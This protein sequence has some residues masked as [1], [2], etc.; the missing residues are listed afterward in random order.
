MNFLK[1]AY[2]NK[3]RLDLKKI[4][5]R[6]SKWSTIKEHLNELL[7]R[8]ITFN[9]ETGK[10]YNFIVKDKKLFISNG[11]RTFPCGYI[12]K[13]SQ[14]NYFTCVIIIPDDNLKIY[15]INDV[16]N[17]GTIILSDELTP[18]Y[19]NETNLNV[20]KHFL[21][22]FN[23]TFISTNSLP[24]WHLRSII[25]L[26]TKLNLRE[27]YLLM[28]E[29]N[30]LS[31]LELCICSLYFKE[32]IKI[33]SFLI[34]IVFDNKISRGITYYHNAKEKAVLSRS[35][36]K[37]INEESF[38]EF[39]SKFSSD[40]IEEFLNLH[41]IEKIIN[42]SAINDEHVKLILHLY[43]NNLDDFYL[44]TP[45]YINAFNSKMN[46][47]NLTKKLISTFYQDLK[48]NLKKLEDMIRLEYGYEGVGSLY[49]ERFI[50]NS[51]KNHFKN[52]NIISEYSPDWLGRQRIDIFIEEINIGI[53]Y[54][55]KQHY[56]PI[57]FFG[58]ES[59]FLEIKRRDN[60]KKQ[61]CENNNV[62]LIEIKYNDD[63]NDSIDFIKKQ[64]DERLN[65]T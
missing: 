42:L 7:K 57:D 40:D 9:D 23:T 45:D 52:L 18:I 19:R 31:P 61:L 10:K 51:L 28:L 41:V 62:K 63:I 32:K 53:E 1:K 20:I 39:L 6:K 46:E 11:I 50:Y 8:E 12:V 38:L 36:I 64:I 43:P 49:S 24:K 37:I 14:G 5:L 30:I 54:N 60:L 17:W 16:K 13:G 58:G 29:H 4:H 65:L 59:G 27:R 26:S 47:I 48:I 3:Y 25:S 33:D 2:E 34:N 56:E 44:G 35:T 22:D 55:G 21:N 15:N